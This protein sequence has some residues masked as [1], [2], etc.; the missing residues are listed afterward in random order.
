[1]W[2]FVN[3]TNGISGAGTV[4]FQLD[5]LTDDPNSNGSF[6]QTNHVW[7]VATSGT[8]AL[9]AAFQLSNAVYTS[10]TFQLTGTTDGQGNQIEQLSFSTDLVPEPAAWQFIAAGLAGMT[11]LR[12]WNRRRRTGLGDYTTSR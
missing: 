9:Q 11:A 12:G 6:W 5:F 7:D 3:A 1:M 4:N 10:G 8:G 2:S